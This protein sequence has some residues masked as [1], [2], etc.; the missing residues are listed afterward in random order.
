MK[1]KI[2]DNK[3]NVIKAINN[4]IVGFKSKRNR[5]ILK[6]HYVEGLTFEEVAEKHNMS[7]RQVKKISYDNEQLIINYLCKERSYRPFYSFLQPLNALIN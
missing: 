1:H 4:C 2:I 3:D 6:D 5:E 7:V